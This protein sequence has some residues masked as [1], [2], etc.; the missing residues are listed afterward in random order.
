M[1]AE[2]CLEWEPSQAGGFFVMFSA[3]FAVLVPPWER[4]RFLQQNAIG[5]YQ[6][7]SVVYPGMVEFPQ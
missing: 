6:L 3:E 7:H 2:Y 5:I 1:A 4:I